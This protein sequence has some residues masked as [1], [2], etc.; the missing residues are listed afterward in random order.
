M[1][2]PEGQGTGYGRAREDDHEF[3]DQSFYLFYCKYSVYIFIW[4]GN[5]HAHRDLDPWTCFSNY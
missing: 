1:G 2:N 5:I 3:P 4:I